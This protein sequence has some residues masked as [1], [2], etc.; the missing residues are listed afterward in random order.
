MPTGFRVDAVLENQVEKLWN[1]AISENTRSVYNTGLQ[2]LLN[3]LLMSGVIFT[4]KCFPCLN[5]DMLIYFVTYCHSSLK[6][7]WTTIKLYLAGIRFHYLKAGQENPFLSV[8]RLQCI[9]RGIKRS[10]EVKSKPRLPI[11]VKILSKLCQLLQTGVFSPYMDKTLECMCLLAFYGFLRCA[12][13]TVNSLASSG[14]FLRICDVTF[15]DD[16]SMFTLSLRSSKTDP[17]RKGVQILYFRKNLLCPVSSMLSFIYS[18]RKQTLGSEAPLF[19]DDRNQPFSRHLF[20]TYL[21][22]LLGR[23]GYKE[24]DYCG[25]SFRIGA[26][27]TAAA[28]GIEDHLIQTLGRWNSSCYMRYIRVSRNVVQEAQR[29]LGLAN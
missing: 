20:V 18:Y 27:T 21:R 1:V 10:Q 22:D 3:F 19:V 15:S 24:T 26:A 23:L 12:E 9:I 7:K 25:H 28:A 17:F 6:L 5:E 4:N 13:F 14:S 2:C 11:D 29:K 16:K 8:D